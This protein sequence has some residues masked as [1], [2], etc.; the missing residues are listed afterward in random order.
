MLVRHGLFAGGCNSRRL[1]AAPLTP[2]PSPQGGGG[3]DQLAKGFAL[4][5]PDGRFKIQDTPIPFGR[6]REQSS[7]FDEHDGLIQD[8]V[9]RSP[10]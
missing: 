3:K 6:K 5:S 2:G 9:L 4:D 10:P 8:F 1:V 7:H